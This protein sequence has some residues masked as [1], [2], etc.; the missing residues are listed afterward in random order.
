MDSNQSNLDS[1]TVYSLESK[2]TNLQQQNASILSA[3][4]AS[5][6]HALLRLK[7]IEARLDYIES[8]QNEIQTDSSEDRTEVS[9]PESPCETECILKSKEIESEF[10]EFKNQINEIRN[11]LKSTLKSI[12]VTLKTMDDA[13]DIIE[14]TYL[15][16]DTF[17][18]TIDNLSQ[19]L[20]A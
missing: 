18:E 9:L 13:I 11:Q 2:I 12:D 6:S 7:L 3:L 1:S 17:N 14:K 4:Q 16:I 5:S 10:L 20:E 15:E 19:E 8:V